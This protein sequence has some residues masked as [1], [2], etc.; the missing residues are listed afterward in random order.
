ML[1][2]VAP[3][4][5]VWRLVAMPIVAET[6]RSSS[7]CCASKPFRRAAATAAPITPYVPCGWIESRVCAARLMRAETS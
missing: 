4:S 1:R 3:S 5:S 7:I 2:T 6:L